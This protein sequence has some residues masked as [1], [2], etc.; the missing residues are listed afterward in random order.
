TQRTERGNHQQYR[1]S[2]MTSTAAMRW[3]ALWDSLGGS[4]T[5]T[6]CKRIWH[7]AHVAREITAARWH[8]RSRGLRRPGQSTVTPMEIHRC[9]VLR[10]EPFQTRSDTRIN[11]T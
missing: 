6:G 9:A 4:T 2:A 3:L 1:H 10:L 11:G 8:G 5:S 7:L